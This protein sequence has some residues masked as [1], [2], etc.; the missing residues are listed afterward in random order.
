MLKE[1]SKRPHF[2][3]Q[4]SERG[5]DYLTARYDRPLLA[6]LALA[7]LVLSIACANVANLLLAKSAARQ[8]EISMRL[9]LGAGRGRIV[10]QLLTEGLV[11]ALLAG[12]A[13]VVFAYSVRNGIPALLTTPWRPSPFDTAFDGRVLVA[14]AG[15]TLLTGV[16]FSLAPVWQSR[17]VDVHDAVKDGGRGGTTLSKLR[18]ARLLVVLQVA[19]SMLLLAGAG[20][21]V[22]TF[23]NLKNA[24]LGFQP[25]GVLVFT[26]DPPRLE[27]TEDRI[28]VLVK[29]L[30]ER[31][32][33]IPGV[34]SATFLSKRG[35]A[36]VSTSFQKAERTTGATPRVAAIGTEFFDT[37][38]IP[39]LYGRPIQAQDETPGPPAAVVNR[40][41]AL[42]FYQGG[43]PVGDTFTGSDGTIYR[44]VGVCGDWH[45]EYL[46]D[47]IPPSF[48]TAFRQKPAAGAIDFQVKVRGDQGRI[49]REIRQALRLIDPNL[50]AVDMRT[51]SEQLD[52][53]LAQERL[54]ASLAAVFGV[55][56]LVLAAIG[57]YGVLAYGVVR[58]TNEIGIRV[59]LGA[60]PASVAWAVL[61]ETLWLALAGVVLGLPAVLVLAPVLN[62]V[63]APGWRVSFVY[64]LQ[65]HDPWTI[66]GAVLILTA[67][68][69]LAGYLPARRAALVDPMTALR[70]A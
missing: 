25:E 56:A 32:S 69:L 1:P 27:Y 21:F 33:A 3:L 8:R 46:R 55:L 68:G 65:V 52:D 2:L 63:I 10:R 50:V 44:V 6:L 66:A 57:I 58:R 9:A 67:T 62:H 15:L 40:R 14:S 34:Q 48:Y 18:T 24:S 12:I 31:L 30:Q 13:G 26:L 20:L 53:A 19:L 4:A 60:R 49:A 28:G 35:V 22:R 17:R 5:L 23:V 64:G 36:M 16:V 47:E 37:M 43:N 42:R 59:A 41:F 51:E 11:L 61:R 38:G 54:L 45:V 70:H 39:I 29:Q 7:G